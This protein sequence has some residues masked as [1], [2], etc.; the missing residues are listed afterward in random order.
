MGAPLSS[1][2]FHQPGCSLVPSTTATVPCMQS[3]NDNPIHLRPIKHTFW[4]P[5]RARTVDSGPRAHGVKLS[6]RFFLAGMSSRAGAASRLHQS[7]RPTRG[8][9]YHA[10]KPDHH[11]VVAPA[12][13]RSHG[14]FQKGLCSFASACIT[15]AHGHT[16]LAHARH[17]AL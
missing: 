15:H 9:L 6:T 1:S 2:Q 11:S 14:I 7:L 17:G 10:P 5:S 16:H 8:S 4:R 3:I 13:G 12:P